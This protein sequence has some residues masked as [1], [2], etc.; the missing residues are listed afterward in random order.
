M[1]LLETTVRVCG[2]G[3]VVR[4]G[5]EMLQGR[6]LPLVRVVKGHVKVSLGKD[7]LRIG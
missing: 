5:L 6:M 7:R 3:W 1:L 4:S 2:L